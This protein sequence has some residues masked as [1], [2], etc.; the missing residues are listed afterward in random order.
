MNSSVNWLIYKGINIFKSKTSL[1][2]FNLLTNNNDIIYICPNL[3]LNQ[4]IILNY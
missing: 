4:H 1:S 2:I 3:Y